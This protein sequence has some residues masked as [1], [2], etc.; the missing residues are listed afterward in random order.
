VAG[1]GKING[2]CSIKKVTIIIILF[3][4][5]LLTACEGRLNDNTDTDD[6]V[7]AEMPETVVD[8]GRH[9]MPIHEAYSENE[10]A[11]SSV[12]HTFMEVLKSNEGFYLHHPYRDGQRVDEME[13]VYL[14]ELFNSYDDGYDWQIS[15]FTIVDMD[16]D[17][18]PEVVIELSLGNER[19]VFHYENGKVYAYPFSYRG[20]NNLKKDGTFLS[21]GGAA[22]T[23][24]NML[25]FSDG[26]LVVR[27]LAYS[28]TVHE[29]GQ[30]IRAVFF[31]N[32]E[33]ITEDM[34]YALL[35]GFLEKED[36]EWH[37][38]NEDYFEVD[39]SAAWS[40]AT[41]VTEANIT[42]VL[43]S[44][45]NNVSET[46]ATENLSI[47]EAVVLIAQEIPFEGQADIEHHKSKWENGVE[48]YN[49]EIHWYGDALTYY[50]I[51]INSITREIDI[52]E[53]EVEYA[54]A[55]LEHWL[56]AG[57]VGHWRLISDLEVTYEFRD[58]GNFFR[59]VNDERDHDNSGSFEISRTTI[60][61]FVES[62]KAETLENV[63]VEGSIMF[64][65]EVPTYQK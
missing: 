12:M 42:A 9:I 52:E 15:Y 18:V 48:F 61:L 20:L 49:F 35:D 1:K 43:L 31:A 65:N 47:D 10:T 34:F 19:M 58:G 13:H 6:S 46:A 53:L 16:G 33:E 30:F 4:V 55:M 26:I 64:V 45:D 41:T 63:R 29:N 60:T 51:W 24:L 25:Q 59:Y 56:W 8:T 17:G 7:L 39:F 22:Y 37:S 44:R 62:G 21:S 2:V 40:A 38:F 36:A 32:D 3:L 54:S 57:L 27:E 11:L 23:Y 5:F 14:N 28:D 50:S